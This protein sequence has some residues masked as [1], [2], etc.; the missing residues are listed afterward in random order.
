ML[1]LSRIETMF[2][3]HGNAWYGGEAISQTAHALHMAAR[4]AR[5]GA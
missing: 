2:A 1:N 5:T 4:C 3:D